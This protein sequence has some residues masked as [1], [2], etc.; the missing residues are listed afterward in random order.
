MF[1]TLRKA[2]MKLNPKKCTFGVETGQFLGYMITN[3]GIR[4]NP[5]KVQA[6]INMASPRTLREVQAL[7][8]NSQHLDAS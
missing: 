8:A 3:E 7:M 2:N 5:K 1:E 6:I 4:A